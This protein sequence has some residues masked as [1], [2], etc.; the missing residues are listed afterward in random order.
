MIE[1]IKNKKDDRYTAKLEIGCLY[2]LRAN[3]ILNYSDCVGAGDTF[4]VLRQIESHFSDK[5][6]EYF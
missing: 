3:W 4:F 2:E 5:K 1:T 6:E